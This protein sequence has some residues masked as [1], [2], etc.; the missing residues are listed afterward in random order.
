MSADDPAFARPI[1]PR[2]TET[3]PERLVSV[4]ESALIDSLTTGLPDAEREHLLTVIA[5][6]I[7]AERTAAAEGNPPR[8]VD[9]GTRIRRSHVVPAAEGSEPVGSEPGDGEPDGGEPGDAG[10]AD[11]APAGT[12]L[13]NAAADPPVRA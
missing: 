8:P 2:S 12:A 6:R 11:T 13:E 3:E 10:L 1:V 7:E 5:G 9:V 4:G